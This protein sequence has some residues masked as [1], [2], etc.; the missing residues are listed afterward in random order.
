M[1]WRL[2]AARPS[3]VSFRSGPLGW[4][5][6]AERRLFWAAAGEK[7]ARRRARGRGRTSTGVLGFPTKMGRRFGTSRRH[8]GPFCGASS[9]F[10]VPFLG[11]GKHAKQRRVWALEFLTRRPRVRARPSAVRLFN[12]CRVGEAPG[13]SGPAVVVPGGSWAAVPARRRCRRRRRAWAHGEHDLRREGCV[14]RGVAEG[15]GSVHSESPCSWPPSPPPAFSSAS[16]AMSACTI[17]G[18]RG[19][20]LADDELSAARTTSEAAPQ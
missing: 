18:S 14:H 7:S 15:P 4:W 10:P 1:R 2:S 12:L 20:L 3:A 9:R 19:E 6:P 16:E 11:G 5:P 8:L 13:C 17:H